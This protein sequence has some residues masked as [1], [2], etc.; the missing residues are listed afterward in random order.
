MTNN[1]LAT[2][3]VKLE[4]LTPDPQ[5]VRTHDSRNL[6]AIKKSL[7]AFGQRKPIVV[8]KANDG[9]LVVIAGNGTLEAARALGWESI[10]VAEVPEDWDADKA[11]A[12]AIADNRTAELADWDEVGLAS[13]LLEL[14]AVGWDMGTLGF[15]P[16]VQD[17]DTEDLEET[18][19]EPPAEPYSK[20]GDV[21]QLGPNHRVV[22]GS[23]A[24]DSAY[25][26]V[27]EG[28]FVDLVWTDPPYGVEYVGKTKDALT[29]QNDDLQGDNLRQFLAD[30]LTPAWAHCR[31]G[32][33]W[34]VAA[35]SGDLFYE[36]ATVLKELKVWRHT[37]AWVKDAFVMGRADYHYRHESIFYGWKDG[38]SH[39]W[40]GGR[41]QDTVVNVARPK[42][43]A[44][45]PTMK[46]VALVAL[47]I[48]NSTHPNDLVLDCFGGSGSTMLAA[49]AK[50]RRSAL[51]ELDPRYV[52]VIC[53]RFQEASGVLPRLVSTD[54]PHDFIV[55]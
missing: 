7:E 33:A 1:K 45:H 38:A 15:E 10:T 11:R 3:E 22:C 44:D 35:P 4:K 39:T 13:A 53:R 6:D 12:Y 50:G 24:D 37:L 21:W 14:D 51:I 48:E 23:A 2:R 20:L 19:A 41:K 9:T 29:I 46:P 18:D 52:D 36:F 32:A 8:A 43:N 30:T 17:L 26:A 25:V 34:Y 47:H 40:N 27:L 16:A 42:R 28:Q 54:E 55:G 49:L 31:P 5:N